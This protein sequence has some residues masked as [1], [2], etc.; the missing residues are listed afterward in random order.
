MKSLKPIKKI[1]IFSA[2][3]ERRGHSR[4]RPKCAFTS[5]NIH[6]GTLANSPVAS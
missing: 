5:P 3:A 1:I 2:I 6:F 4:N